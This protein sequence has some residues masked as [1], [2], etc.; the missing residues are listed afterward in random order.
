[1][2]LLHLDPRRRSTNGRRA[3]TDARVLHM[4]GNAHID[5]VWLWQWPEGYQEVRATFQ[6]AIDRMDEYPDFVF[7]CDSVALLRSGSR[8]ATRS[9][10]SGSARASPRDAGRSSAAGGSSPTAT[11]RAASRSCARRSTA[12]ATCT[13]RFGIT[14]TT[15]ANL[16]SFGHNATIPQ[17][18]AQE[19]HGLVRL[20][21]ARARRERELP[22]AD[23]LVGVAGR[24]ARARLP[25]PA[26]VLR[27]ARTTSASTSRRRSRRCPTARDELMRLLRRRQPRRR[28]DEGEPR[29]DRAAERARRLPRLELSSLRRV[30]RRASPATAS[31][32][33]SAASCSTTR[34][35]ATRRTPASSAGTAAPRTCCCAP[36]SGARSPTRSAAGRIRSRELTRGLEAA[37]L[38]PVPRHARRHLDRAGLRGCARPDRPRVVDRGERVQPA[39]QSIARQIDDRARRRRCGPSSSSTR[40]RGRCGADV[41][42]EYTWLREP[43]APHVVDDEGEPVPMQLTRPLDD[44]ERR[45]RPARLPGRAAAARLPHLPGPA[46]RA[47]ARRAARGGRHAARERALLLELDPAT[48]RIARLVVKATGADL[49]APEAHAR[50]RRRRPLRHLGPRRRRPT[51][52]RSASS[53]ATSV[54]LRRDGPGARDPARREPLRRLDARART[55]SS[56]ADARHVDVRV[57]LDWREQLK[58]LKLR[59]PTTVEAETATFETPYGHVE[60]PADGDEEPGQAW[61]DVSGDGRRPGGAE[62]REVRA[63]TSRGGR[64]RHHAPSAAPV[65]AWHDPRELEEG[66]DFEYMDQGRQTF[67]VRLV[68]HAGDWRAAG[69]VAAR[70]RAEPAAVRADRDASTPGR[71]R[72]ARRSPTTAAACR[73]HG[74]EARPRTATRSSCA[75]TRRAGPRRARA[76]SSVLGRDDRRRLRR[77]TRSRR[78]VPRDGSRCARRTCSSGSVARAATAGSCAAASATSGGG[79]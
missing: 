20:P 21:A 24:L 30:L 47:V 67:H 23:L 28:P 13:R 35:A 45:A 41:E 22:G 66:G 39:V 36:R 71:C 70:R 51:T 48:G 14:A 43:R 19:R 3:M 46:R 2:L 29:P 40:T 17:I 59:Y 65:W 54:R 61:V 44:D 1:M 77:R 18:L 42:L 12:S 16:D 32:R 53:S 56:R 15:G 57:A 25:H 11:S 72:S 6:S 74:R 7:T 73:R 8:R 9:S 69:V 37:A 55:T 63:T 49:A 62:R 34:P 33:S 76:R 52:T 31:C 78:S 58:L 68:P 60:R 10:S 4:I 27:A 26:R 50:G 5:P 64:H 38:Q 79:T 75:P